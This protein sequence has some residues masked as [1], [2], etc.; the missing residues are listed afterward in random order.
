MTGRIAAII[1]LPVR[2]DVGIASMVAGRGEVWV[3]ASP[4]LVHI[5]PRAAAVRGVVGF[6]SPHRDSGLLGAAAIAVGSPTV[7]ITG[8]LD[9]PSLAH[10]VARLDPATSRFLRPV[11][12]PAGVPAGV[13]VGD[14]S[15]WVSTST[16]RIVRIDGAT[17]T[18]Q[19]VI[20]VADSLD[21]VVY[22]AGF[23]WAADV[24]GG[25]VYRIDPHTETVAAPVRVSGTPSGLAAGEGALW[26]LDSLAG[27]VRSLGPGSDRV[28]APIRVGETATAIAVGLG[29]VWVSALDGTIREIDPRT[30]DVSQIEVGSPLAAIA[31]D[32]PSRTVWVTVARTSAA[33]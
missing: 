6:G 25:A 21:S 30:G 4:N 2:L 9:I 29:S 31:V 7:W 11:Q 15:A 33:G 24:L 26:I 27:T 5:D 14:G 32:G 13:A 1:H 23:V 19:R 12:I 3:N 20:P 22:G 18:V 10:R 16:G 8:G 28:G 17:G